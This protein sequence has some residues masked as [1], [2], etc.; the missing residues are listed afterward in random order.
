MFAV[1]RKAKEKLPE[2]VVIEMTP[3]EKEFQKFVKF[4]EQMH[5]FTESQDFLHVAAHLT[6]T[7]DLVGATRRSD[8][9]E[10]RKSKQAVSRRAAQRICVARHCLFQFCNAYHKVKRP[11]FSFLGIVKQDIL[12]LQYLVSLHYQCKFRK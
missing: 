6:H 4:S 12:F 9:A 2:L 3:G 7:T 10:G 8:L 5:I 1:A 11:F